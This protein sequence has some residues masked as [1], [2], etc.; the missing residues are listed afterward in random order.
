MLSSASSSSP[1]PALVSRNPVTT[2]PAIREATTRQPCPPTRQ[3][4]ANRGSKGRGAPSQSDKKQSEVS[5]DESG[6]GDEENTS[7]K[8]ESQGVIESAS[9]RSLSSLFG[10]TE[11]SIEQEISR[12]VG[13]EQLTRLSRATSVRVL[14][15]NLSLDPSAVDTIITHN[16]QHHKT[17]HLSN[18]S[19]ALR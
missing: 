19:S 2:R 17:R 9:L 12:T 11:A 13:L 18:A 16:Q 8:Q 10:Q 6:S 5:K 1:E 4:Q 15:H 3:P 7:D 14:V